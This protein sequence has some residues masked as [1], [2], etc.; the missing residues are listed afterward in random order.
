MGKTKGL[1]R[2][3]FPKGSSVRIVGRPRLEDFLASWKYHNKLTSEQL[4]YADQIAEVES[5]GYYHGGDELYVLKGI[6]GIWHEQCLESYP[7]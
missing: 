6:P 4:N 7:S 3:E 1:Y 5:V 2:E